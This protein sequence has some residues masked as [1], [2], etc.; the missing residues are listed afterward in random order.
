M[1]NWMRSVPL[2]AVLIL[3]A[4]FTPPKLPGQQFTGAIAGTI[5]DSSGARVAG[6]KVKADNTSTNLSV[7][8]QSAKDGSYLIATLPI[9]AC[10]VT[11][12][13]TGFKTESHTSIVVEGNRT[14]TVDG[15]LEIGT[16]S[17]TV[18]VTD[19]PLLNRVDTTSG[20]V[21]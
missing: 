19:T 12:T 20:Y 1:N 13:M 21:L 6:A 9:G 4:S 3:I 16:L 5:S 15:K 17:T 8:A 18:E 11:I 7:T 14:T 10:S 2:A